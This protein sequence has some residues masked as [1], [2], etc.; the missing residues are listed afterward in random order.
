MHDPWKQGVQ[1]ALVV[2]RAGAAA[3]GA[4]RQSLRGRPRGQAHWLRA[5][6]PRASALAVGIRPLSR[7]LTCSLVAVGD[8]APHGHQVG[9]QLRQGAREAGRQPAARERRLRRLPA[10][11]PSPR[12]GAPG[13]RA[14]P[15]SDP[16]GAPRAPRSQALPASHARARTSWRQRCTFGMSPFV[17]ALSRSAAERPLSLQPATSRGPPPT[18]RSSMF[19]FEST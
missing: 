15:A 16:H 6:P 12:A 17:A 3:A 13:L 19:T 7:P 9:T 14:R 10:A 11:R 2:A 5:T 4:K 1:A 8:D 18:M